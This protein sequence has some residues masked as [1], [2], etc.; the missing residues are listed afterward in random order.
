MQIQKNNTQL[1]TSGVET[2][3]TSP[4]LLLHVSGIEIFKTFLSHCHTMVSRKNSST[5]HTASTSTH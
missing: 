5:H 2:A 3:A 1:S 4:E